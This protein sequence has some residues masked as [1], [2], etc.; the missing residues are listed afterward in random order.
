MNGTEQEKKPMFFSLPL[1]F[2][3]A[4]T[5]HLFDHLI[6]IL[7]DENKDIS[8]AKLRYIYCDCL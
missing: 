8:P 6:F 7:I 1:S 2:I 5:F 3:A 4:V